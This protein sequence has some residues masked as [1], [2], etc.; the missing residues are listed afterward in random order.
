[1][2]T[3]EVPCKKNMDLKFMQENITKSVTRLTKSGVGMRTD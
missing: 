2:A 3:K 1:M